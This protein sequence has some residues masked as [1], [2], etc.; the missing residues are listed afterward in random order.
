MRDNISLMVAFYFVH[1]T[2]L[3]W[4]VNIKFKSTKTL[5]VATGLCDR[6]CYLLGLQDRGELN[7]FKERQKV[8]RHKITNYYKYIWNTWLF[9]YQNIINEPVIRNTQI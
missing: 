5:A 6:I 3:A 2:D 4:R 9:Y 8:N 7:N 1:I